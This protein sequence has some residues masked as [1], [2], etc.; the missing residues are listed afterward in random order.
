[1]SS[2][3]N[4]LL[5]G[6]WYGHVAALSIVVFTS[7]KSPFLT[8]WVAAGGVCIGIR[9]FIGLHSNEKKT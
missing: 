2:G 4:A 1:M 5:A 3:V 6:V 9:V 8:F 7:T